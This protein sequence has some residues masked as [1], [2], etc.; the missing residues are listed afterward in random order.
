MSDRI[1][2]LVPF[3]RC[4]GKPNQALGD[5]QVICAKHWR[6]VG[7]LTKRAY[8]TARRRFRAE[9]E[10]QNDVEQFT[11]LNWLCVDLWA[12]ASRQAIESAA[13]LR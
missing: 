4:T 2:C 3:C 1:P 8:R 12:R 9:A 7:P 11:R 10:R 6:G 13:G 5:T